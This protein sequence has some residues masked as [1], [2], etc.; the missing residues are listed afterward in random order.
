MI[1]RIVEESIRR[2]PKRKAL[3]IAAIA[4]GAA[5]ATAMLGVMLDIG[6]KINHELR[7]EGANIVVTPQGASLTGGIGSVAAAVAG[8]NYISEAQVPKLKTIFWGLNI[9]GFSPSLTTTDGANTVQGV[10]FKHP[11]K[12]PSGDAQTTGIPDVNPAWQVQGAWPK[13]DAQDCIAG[14]AVARRNGW[15]P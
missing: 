3:A 12:A 15:Q 10:W 8:D 4:M 9:T 5:V 13:D 1:F 7:A 14:A 2:A 11:Y 6:D